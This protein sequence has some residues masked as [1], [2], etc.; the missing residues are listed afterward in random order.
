[1]TAAHVA[2]FHLLTRPNIQVRYF[3]AGYHQLP[4]FWD[5]IERV[6]A[7]A[8]AS[9]IHSR[10]PRP[11]WG[12][13]LSTGSSL[14]AYVAGGKAE[15]HNELPVGLTADVMLTTGWTQFPTEIRKALTPVILGDVSS[16]ARRRP[17]PQWFNFE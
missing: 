13:Q 1:M 14:R 6:L 5:E 10:T 9:L 3:A 4:E 15:G 16:R 12:M 7:P 2:L 11:A 8:A 17:S